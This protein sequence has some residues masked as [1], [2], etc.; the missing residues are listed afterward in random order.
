MFGPNDF[1]KGERVRIYIDAGCSDVEVREG[2]VSDNDCV[3]GGFVSG[4]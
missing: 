3:R 2:E 1:K 4:L